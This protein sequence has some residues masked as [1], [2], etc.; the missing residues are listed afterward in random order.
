METEL[1]ATV[2]VL[3][4]LALERGLTPDETVAV[5]GTL[6]V[7]PQEVTDAYINEMRQT[8]TEEILH[9]PGLAK[10]DTHLDAIT[11]EQ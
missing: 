6:A 8:S 4:A 9:H 3:T 2:T 7:S 11:H 5:A 10:L 1:R